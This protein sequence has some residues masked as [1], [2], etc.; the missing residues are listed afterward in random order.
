MHGVQQQTGEFDELCS[1]AHNIFWLIWVIKFVLATRAKSPINILTQAKACSRC[2]A[3]AYCS[4]VRNIK[5]LSNTWLKYLPPIFVVLYPPTP[6]IWHTSKY[7]HRLAK[8]KIGADTGPTATLLWWLSWKGGEGG[9]WLLERFLYF[10]PWF[11]FDLIL[12]PTILHLLISF[13]TF[14]IFSAKKLIFT[15]LSFGFLSNE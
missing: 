8:R 11:K 9:W 14:C 2:K 13:G 5:V 1:F 15:G 3:V 10:Y 12:L 4:Q 6:I 7:Q